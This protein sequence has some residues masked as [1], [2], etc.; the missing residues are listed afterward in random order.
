[1]VLFL[2]LSHLALGIVFTLVFV[3]RDAG[4]KFFRFNSGLAAA[5]LAAAFAFN[6]TWGETMLA[7]TAFVALGVAEAAILFYWATVGRGLASI[8]PAIVGVSCGAGLVALVAQA[9]DT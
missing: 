7:R 8:R 2:F 9:C 3:S 1:M 6:A 5:L 4:V